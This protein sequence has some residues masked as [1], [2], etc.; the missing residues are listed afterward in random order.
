M[1]TIR[2]LLDSMN[3][4]RDI[5]EAL[6]ELAKDKTPALV[7]NEVDALNQVVN[8]ES[9]L[10]RL[11]GEAEQQRIQII[12]E[13]LLSRGYNPNPQITISDLI[14]IIFKAEEKHALSEA[15]FSLLHVLHE[16][17]ERNAINQQLIEQSLAFIDYSLDLVMGSSEDEAVYHNPNQQ[18]SGNRLGVF[19]TKA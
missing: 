16:L 11:I 2:D 6:L 14:K 5:H 15:Q 7:H 13:Y 17:K 10:M 3:K 1:S 8:K 9:K 19:D 12:N 18:K 4:L